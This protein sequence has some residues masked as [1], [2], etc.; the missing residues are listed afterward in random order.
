MAAVTIQTHDV[1]LVGEW[2]YFVVR[3]T[4][5]GF[6]TST[7]NGLHRVRTNGA[8]FERVA[9]LPLSYADRNGR[10]T[11]MAVNQTHFFFTE[12]Y[13]NIDFPLLGNGSRVFATT[14]GQPATAVAQ[15]TSTW[16]N[17]AQG[18]VYMEVA[19]DN[20]NAF[21]ARVSGSNLQDSDTHAPSVERW[22]LPNPMRDFSQ[23]DVLTT[24]NYPTEDG[25]EAL[26]EFY[27]TD[28]L[29]RVASLALSPDHLYI[30]NATTYIRRYNLNPFALQTAA[31]STTPS[32]SVIA[33]AGP[34]TDRLAFIYV[35]DLKY[36]TFSQTGPDLVLGTL[37]SHVGVPTVMAADENSVFTWLQDG[38]D[39]WVLYEMSLGGD[40]PSLRLQMDR[41]VL[42][43]VRVNHI[44]A[45]AMPVATPSWV[46]G[47][48][49]AL[50]VQ[51]G[52]HLKFR[53]G[54][55]TEDISAV[56][57]RR[58]RFDGSQIEYLASE[59]G[60]VKWTS[61]VA[62]LPRWPGQ[63]WVHVH[64]G[65]GVAGLTHD[66]QVAVQ[67]DNQ[68]SGFSTAKRIRAFSQTFYMPD[69][70]DDDEQPP[71]IFYVEQVGSDTGVYKLSSQAPTTYVPIMSFISP[72]DRWLIDT[73]AQYLYVWHEDGV[74]GRLRVALKSQTTA[75]WSY[76][77]HRL[78]LPHTVDDMLAH[79]RFVYLSYHTSDTH[80]IFKVDSRDL[81]WEVVYENDYVGTAALLS[82]G[83]GQALGTVGLC[84]NQIRLF[85]CETG[86]NGFERSLVLR[87]MH[88]TTGSVIEYTS[89]QGDELEV[90]EME[91]LDRG[92]ATDWGADFFSF[93]RD[94]E[95]SWD[96]SF[97][98]SQYQTPDAPEG[99]DRTPDPNGRYWRRW[100]MEHR[101]RSAFGGWGKA[102]HETT[103][104][105]TLTIGNEYVMLQVRNDQSEDS[106]TNEV[107]MQAWGMPF[108]ATPHDSS[109]FIQIRRRSD[110]EIIYQSLSSGYSRRQGSW[111]L[112]DQWP[113][114]A[115]DRWTVAQSQWHQS[116]SFLGV[117]SR[118]T[119]DDLEITDDLLVEFTIRTSST[120]TLAS[121]EQFRPGSFDQVLY[122]TDYVGKRSDKGWIPDSE[123]APVNQIV[124]HTSGH[125]DGA[126]FFWTGAAARLKHYLDAT[127]TAYHWFVDQ[128][129]TVRYLEADR[130]RAFHAGVEGNH[131]AGFA[132]ACTDNHFS[133]THADYAGAT[134]VQG[135]IDRAAATLAPYMTGQNIANVNLTR[136]Q[137]VQGQSGWIVHHQL[138]PQ[139]DCGEHIPTA[140]LLAAI[141]AE[142]AN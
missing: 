88:L 67:H 59:S 5:E 99:D 16:P 32:G 128:S 71:D 79:D 26:A 1:N 133:T 36:R 110:N 24:L 116:S 29:G 77:D 39:Q 113:G 17:G 134:E 62:S 98:V 95:P 132:F 93:L 9:T 19:A 111:A 40:L 142:Q 122:E 60:D 68:W 106:F 45:T 140:A 66:Y 78:D 115:N 104:D 14:V 75:T 65:W 23:A 48:Y 130:D 53:R 4:V 44:H 139:V 41:Q 30:S 100:V 52:L 123:R 94:D 76:Q 63:H 64:S 27:G 42:A 102:T 136:E 13:F 31:W 124:I 101:S 112:A 97:D 109:I 47:S 6:S 8:D 107:T 73:D 121:Q 87:S 34:N 70:D 7:P 2:V 37:P 55:D 125:A 96:G 118:S 129:T 127:R 83:D 120:N 141:S 91:V 90:Y 80:G 35:N 103:G 135:I 61:E 49:A 137:F 86:G 89:L 43:A 12:A 119:F 108:A 138:N 82:T 50:N 57:V 51:D 56:M 131:A 46:D 18:R 58:Q 10:V 28:L 25:L 85:W 72:I 105:R 74:S 22:R 15:R 92:S 54:D 84:S 33:T 126:G 3:E 38:E 117:M 81:S 20:A 21:V 11:S 69:D 114:S